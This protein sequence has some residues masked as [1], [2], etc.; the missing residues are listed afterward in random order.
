MKIHFKKFIKNFLQFFSR[1]ISLVLI[2]MLTFF[3]IFGTVFF[4]YRN[5]YKKEELFPIISKKK[6]NQEIFE[7]LMKDLEEAQKRIDQA[8]SKEYPDPFR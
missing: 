4:V 8:M 7:G 5:L 1:R 6:I 3:L 2:L